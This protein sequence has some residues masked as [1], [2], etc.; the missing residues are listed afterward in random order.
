MIISSEARAGLE[1]LREAAV[2]LRERPAG[3]WVA[4]HGAGGLRPARALVQLQPDVARVAEPESGAR[5]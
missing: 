5:R 4:A 2:E 3:H 1:L